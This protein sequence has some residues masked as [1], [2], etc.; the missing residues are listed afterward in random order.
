MKT[1]ITLVLAAIFSAS[2]AFGQISFVGSGT[3]TSTPVNAPAI[4]VDNALAVTSGVSFDGAKVSVSTNFNT[5][6]LLAYTGSLPSGVSAAYN[7]TTGV[8]S[9]TG[10]ATA[11]AYQALLR[12]VTFA[13]SSTNAL[14]RTVLFNLG[15]DFAYAANGHLYEFVAGSFSWTSA[16]ADAA[17]RIK[18]GMQGYL[19]TITSSGENDFIT[20]K[21]ASN[22]WIGA[23]DDDNEINGGVTYV[24]QAAA[25]GKWYWVTGPEAG[26]QF[27][28]NNGT[29]TQLTYMNW[30]SGEPNNSGTNEHYG[31][32]FASVST[33]KWNDLPN[34]SL[35]GYVVE[36]G[37]MSGDPAVD[38]I[39]T[40]DIKLVATSLQTTG[41]TNVYELHAPA[42]FVDNA[43]IIYSS[44]SITN[45]KVTIASG[46]NSGDVLNF[47]A[48]SL[49]GGVTGSYNS[50]TGILSFTGSATPAAWQSLFRTVTFNSSSNV[51]GDRTVA[52]S[53]GN[54]ASGSNGH[55]YEVVGTT[56]DWTTAR[57][58]AAAKT[59]LGLQGYLATITTQTENDFIQQKMSAD[60]WIGV[61]D[62][63]DY[64]N[65][66]AGT[67][68]AA[69]TNSEGKWYWITGPEAGQQITTANA[70]NATSWPP[71]FGSAYNN[72]NIGE[73]NNSGGT[74][75]YAII[76][77]TGANPGKWNDAGSGSFPYVVEYGGLATDPLL[78]LSANRTIGIYAI[79]PVSDLEFSVT[80]SGNNADL[81]WS[82]SSEKNTLH[83]ELLHSTDATNF[84]KFAEVAATPNSSGFKTYTYT[85]TGPISGNNFYKLKVVDRDGKTTFSDVKQLNFSTGVFS[86]APNPVITT[87]V[88]SAPFENNSL[89]ILKNINGAVVLKQPITSAQTLV[90]ISN[91]SSGVYLAEIVSGQKHSAVIKIIKK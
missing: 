49:P 90:N 20:L 42:T 16:K 56:T 89:L 74:E 61:S 23:S 35:L 68:Y 48:G 79:L 8:L 52:F 85:H 28:N 19:T 18:L 43:L 86:I 17:T 15:V 51:K 55:F 64:I 91:L 45:S 34:T 4:V 37:G 25:E 77:S 66:V 84:T 3:T 27:S 2:A 88:V 33:G 59:Y 82:T 22:G 29:P 10:T 31:Q 76:Y 57:S 62:R 9:F 24:N 36:Y 54:L 53:V 39:H 30:N 44:G 50:T 78:Q 65:P 83:F 70:P 40:R 58:S 71:V 26:T 6:D 67:S 63:Y 69:Q 80:K 13:T 12:T 75:H 60:A 7:S 41:T 73:P 38:I 14:Q 1:P 46:F 47:N 81:K 11:A 72:W 87:F 21:L 32:I 5:G